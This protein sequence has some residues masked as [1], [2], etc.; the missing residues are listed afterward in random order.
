MKLRRIFVA[1]ACVLAAGLGVP[2]PAGAAPQAV[3]TIVGNLSVPWG[4]AFLP[5]G[6][7]LTTERTTGRVLSIKGGTATEVARIPGVRPNGEGGLLGIAVSP[8]YATDGW[9]YVYYTAASDNRIARFKLGGAAPQPILT[10][11]AKN[12]FH[13]GGG[14]AFGPDRMLY[15][16]TGD[17]GAR[18]NAQ[19]LNSL[20]G[21]ILRLKPDGTAAPGNPFNSRVYSYGHRN[22]QGVTWAPDGRMYASEFGE[23]T[24]DELNRI[25]A[26]KNYGWPNC[27]GKCGNPSYVDPLLVWPTRQASPSG[28]AV[29]KGSVYLAALAGQRLWRAQ[30]TGDGGVGQPQSLYQGQY[31]RLRAAAVAPDGTLWFSTSN[32]D[33]RGSPGSSDDRI[34]STDGS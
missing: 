29:Y 23:N 6:T 22:V 3:R 13:D 10:G 12:S 26:G 27:E 34:L 2:P 30:L 28:I 16:T 17:A 19:N 15:A 7:A 20:N 25:E 5:D 32:R 18:A 14:L 4:L 9:L 24:W 1:A 8:D 11:I 33:G 21:K 31:G